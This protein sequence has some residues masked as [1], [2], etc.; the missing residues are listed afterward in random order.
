MNIPNMLI[1]VVITTMNR[2]IA[3]KSALN[4]VLSQSYK[5]K[6][7]LVVIDGCEKDN[8]LYTS[9]IDE[10]QKQVDF[11]FLGEKKNGH[12]PSFARNVGIAHSRGDY[13]AFLDDDDLWTD[14]EHLARFV[15]FA[16]E[17]SCGL[18][19]LYLCHQNAKYPDDQIHV[20]AIWLEDLIEKINFGPSGI[21]KVSV[22][23]L[24]RSNGFSHMNCIIVL[25]SLVL[26]VNGF[27]EAL[28]YEEDR[29]LYYRLLDKASLI[30]MSNNYI[31]THFIPI[32]RNSASKNSSSVNRCVQQ[33][34]SAI[35]LLSILKD[36]QIVKKVENSAAY[37]ARH[38]ANAHVSQ[39]ELA[40]AKRLL[41][42]SLALKFSL[43]ALKEL[44]R[45]L[46]FKNKLNE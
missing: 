36:K 2:P 39:N 22:E 17:Q 28:R 30:F 15:G 7:I 19:E 34:Q 45:I 11:I 14:P 6:Q 18:P 20:G 42:F 10:F 29:D 4:S 23:K 33:L 41:I 13:I 44:A 5:H 12:G 27:D 3:I 37:T 43:G 25:R 40:S 8:G 9:V 21:I 32:G 1:S 26:C 46:I 24:L 16:S 38:L 35:K 31:G